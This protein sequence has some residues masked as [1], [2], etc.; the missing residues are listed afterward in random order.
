[1]LKILDRQLIFNYVKSYLVC[2]TSLMGLFIV[3]DL[4]MNMEPLWESHKDDFFSFI[5]IYYAAK[6]TLIFDRLSEAIVLM[7]AMF[8]IAWMQRNNEILP[9]LSAGVST[10]RIVRPVLLGAWLMVS[11]AVL[12]QELMLPRIDPNLVEN[13]GDTKGEK[14]IAVVGGY[15]SNGIHISGT[16]GYHKEFTVKDFTVVFPNKAPFEGLPPLQA[17]EAKYRPEGYN[18]RPHAGWEL[19]GTTPPTLPE[20]PESDGLLENP[21]PGKYFLRTNEVDFR[22]ATRAKNWAIYVP[23]AKLLD[24]LSRIGQSK[25]SSV[26]VLFHCRLTRPLLGMLLV[27][28]GLSIILRD[29]NRNIFI[30]TGLCLM[31]AAMFFLTS[32]GCKFL[33]DHDHVAPVIAAWLP[34]IL[35]GPL[36]FVMFDAVH[37]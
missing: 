24:E 18:G 27:F 33:G 10:R 20:F 3:V 9:L 17:K 35:F 7:A 34:V 28:M 32:F 30:S 19:F 4:F 25:L 2:L 16:R 1:M 8:T 5:A 21:V 13:R 29:Q 37:T 26:A 22:A 23:T 31:L 6:S 14:E 15:E 36:S 12:N 11:L